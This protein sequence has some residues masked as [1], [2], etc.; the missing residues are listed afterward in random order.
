MA[1]QGLGVFAGN[2][3]EAF[4][5]AIGQK[6][7]RKDKD[8]LAKQQAKLIELQLQA[9]QVKLNA[10]TTLA[11]LMTGT[12]EEFVPAEP[13]TTPEGRFEVP[14]FTNASQQPMDLASIL[15]DPEGQLA[16]VQ[17]G[18]LNIGDLLD[19]QAKQDALESFRGAGDS[20]GGSGR[21][22]ASGQPEFI[23]GPSTTQIDTSGKQVISRPMVANPAFQETAVAQ[24]GASSVKHSI[25]GVDQAIALMGTLEGTALQAGSPFGDISGQLQSGASALG[26]SDFF[27]LDKTA[28]QRRQRVKKLFAE[29][30]L[31]GEQIKTLGALGQ[32]S[33][34]KLELVSA[35]SADLENGILANSLQMLDALQI[36][37]ENAEILGFPVDN[38]RAVLQNI[39]ERREKITQE[40]FGGTQD[41]VTLGNGQPLFS[42]AEGRTS[43]LQQQITA[44]KSMGAE[45]ILDLHSSGT[46][47]TQEARKAATARLKELNKA[48]NDSKPQITAI[49]EMGLTQLQQLLQSGGTLVGDTKRAIDARWKELAPGRKML[50][51]KVAMEI[52]S[53]RES[54]SKQI[55][56]IKDFSEDDLVQLAESGLQLADDVR[57]E[58]ERR[59]DELNAGK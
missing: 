26:V 19:F 15:S 23:P 59:W 34:A 13:T 44:I 37:V 14:Q 10:Q 51:M 32:I 52:A 50:K 54:I 30:L 2:F 55:S 22:D 40:L 12:V 9:G 21:T 43:R 46:V 48:F 42:G 18:A 47:L 4:S 41:G 16:A 39:A 8:A 7:D 17:S 45:A 27:G 31:S 6:K 53:A 28:P 3:A 5:G 35:A 25:A 33:N 11:D 36:K 20:G 29:N 38:P 57:A 49:K 24:T 58:A 56:V 1:N